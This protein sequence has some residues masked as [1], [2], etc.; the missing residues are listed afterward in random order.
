MKAHLL[1]RDR[2]LDPEQPLPPNADALIQDLEL[3]TLWNAMAGGD[4]FF[5]DVCRRVVLTGLD[6]PD[7]I[8][9]RQGILADCLAH[10]EVVR[11]IY[12]LTV[13]TLQAARRVW[14][15][16]LPESALYGSVQLLELF[17]ET[18]TRL[19]R[20]T[21]QHAATF[22]S[23]GL[24]AL[25]GMLAAELDDDYFA[26]IKEHLAR[27]RFKSGVLLSAE[28]GKGNKGANYVLRR[29]EPPAKQPLFSRL[30]GRSRAGHSFTIHE[31]DEAGA[32][33]LSELRGRGIT[34]VV[35]AAY[36]SA[37]HILSF[38]RMLQTEL[39][40]YLC[41]VHL[42][43]QLTRKGEPTCF[44][45]PVAAGTWALQAEGLYDP[46]LSLMQ[47]QRVVGNDVSGDGKQ[48]V[49]ITGANQGGKSTFLRSLGLAQL[50]LQCGLFVPAASFRANIC[51]AVFTHFKREEDATMQSGKLDEEL[52]RMS[53]IA[54]LVSANCLVLFNESFA[55]TNEREG[56]E[57]ARQ[58]IHA[59][60][61]AGVKVDFVTHLYDLAHSLFRQQSRGAL[62]LR[63]QRHADGRRTFRLT[64]GEPLPTSFGEDV[65][66]R[67]FGA[68][69]EAVPAP[70]SR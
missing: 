46:C 68:A 34:L 15:G 55:A 32:R 52:S 40:F 39:A 51:R 23:E 20:I 11:E 29:F 1:Y 8:T 16:S 12:V 28:L 54:D 27:L 50:M 37:D 65:Y 43:A 7:A 6:D 25:F 30:S 38:L 70:S 44:P 53:D 3:T 66:R 59:L 21:D 36:Q 17:V 13:E 61:E 5:F 33:A 41:G 47:E 26:E 56:S 49:M 4:P 24:R 31:R 62:F 60:L 22:R 57:I 35:N 69:P 14:R 18:L 63:A 42:H 10:R 45:A 67:V 48:L 58:V 64:E 9:Y 19:R 2:D